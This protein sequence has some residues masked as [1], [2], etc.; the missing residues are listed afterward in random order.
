MIVQKVV[1]TT[2]TNT[3]QYRHNNED[4]RR[5]QELLDLGYHIV[6]SNII[7]NQIEY[8]VA[9]EVKE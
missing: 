6:M 7:G 8:I 1:R 3:N 9:K 4:T 2:T 5:L